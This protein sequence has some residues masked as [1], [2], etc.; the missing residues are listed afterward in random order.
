[1]PKPKGTGY[2][3]EIQANI[4]KIARQHHD[5]MVKKDDDDIMKKFHYLIPGRSRHEHEKLISKGYSVCEKNGRKL[6]CFNCNC[7]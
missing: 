1:M 7:K 4:V 2:P 3:P 5:N 6:L